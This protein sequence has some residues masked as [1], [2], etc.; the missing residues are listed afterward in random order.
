LEATSSCYGIVAAHLSRLNVLGGTCIISGLESTHLRRDLNVLV[1]DPIIS[2]ISIIITSGVGG[3][4]ISRGGHCQVQS[5]DWRCTGADIIV[6]RRGH[7][8]GRDQHQG[9]PSR[10]PGTYASPRL[11]DPGRFTRFARP[12]G[13]SIIRVGLGQERYLGGERRAKA[14][15]RMCA[16]PVDWQCWQAECGLQSLSAENSCRHHRTST[17]L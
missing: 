17:N 4:I 8:Q 16:R 7:G 1:E 2:I 10:S 12:C 6:D 5:Q 11:R 15:A 13:A 14:A 9:Q 3:A